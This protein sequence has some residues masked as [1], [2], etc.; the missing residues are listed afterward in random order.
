MAV[1]FW[2]VAHWYQLKQLEELVKMVLLLARKD[3][4]AAIIPSEQLRSS[5]PGS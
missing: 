5:A 4:I 3:H 2:V 1:E